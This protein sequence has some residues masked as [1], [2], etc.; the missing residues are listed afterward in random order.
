MNYYTLAFT[1][2][3]PHKL[4]RGSHQ[5]IQKRFDKLLEGFQ[6]QGGEVVLSGGALGVDSWAIESAIR[7]GL[8]YDLF[9]PFPQQA[10]RWTKEQQESYKRYL[11]L[12]QF[13]ETFSESYSNQA[14][15]RSQR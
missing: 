7:V 11:N 3:R 12:A 10:D 15:F 8:P 6:K 4:P 5:I 1:G 9:V 14:F 2:N 13:V